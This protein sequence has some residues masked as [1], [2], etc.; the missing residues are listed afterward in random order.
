[1]WPRNCANKAKGMMNLLLLSSPQLEVWFH[2]SR[3]HT[4]SPHMMSRCPLSTK[5]WSSHAVFNWLNATKVSVILAQIRCQHLMVCVSLLQMLLVNMV[6]WSTVKETMSCLWLETGLLLHQWMNNT[7]MIPFCGITQ[8]QTVI[9]L[10][11]SN[12]LHE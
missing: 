6:S 1:M 12:M 7:K 11:M 10:M 5:H 4:A 9:L 3:Q 2:L 8:S